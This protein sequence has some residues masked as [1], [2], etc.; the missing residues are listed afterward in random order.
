MILFESN[1]WI[2]GGTILYSRPKGFADIDGVKRSLQINDEIIK[3]IQN[4]NKPFV[5]IEDYS[6]LKGSSLKARKIFIDSMNDNELRENLIF[7]NT[8]L[9]STVAIKIGKK[10]NLTGKNI[11]I[12]NSYSDAIRRAQIEGKIPIK[13]QLEDDVLETIQNENANI[14]TLVPINILRKEEWQIRSKEFEN[15]CFVLNRNILHSK[16]IG[17]LKSKHIKQIDQMRDRC[18]ADLN[19]I[20]SSIDYIIVDSKGI[21][22]ATRTSRLAFMKSI[23]IW[24]S[25]HPLKLYCMYNTNTFMRTALNL[26]R[27]FLPFKIQVATDF[28]N[29]LEK[30]DQHKNETVDPIK[31]SQKN[32][33][34]KTISEN[35]LE[36]LV[37]LIGNINWEFKGLND[38][39]HHFDE[40]HPFYYISQSISLIKEELDDLVAERIRLEEQLFQSQKMESIGRLAG[41]IAHDFNNIL[42]IILGNTELGLDNLAEGHPAYNNLKDIKNGSLRG[43]SIVKQLLNFSRK[44]PLDFRIVKADKVLDKSL[45]FIRSAIPENIVINKKLQADEVAIKVDGTQFQQVIMNLFVNASQAIGHESGQIY[46]QS[47]T[48][49]LNENE[50]TQYVDLKAGSYFKIDIFDTGSGISADIKDKIFEPYFTTKDIG[51]GTGMGLAVVHG[52]IKNHK[53]AIQFESVPGEGCQFTILIPQVEFQTVVEKSPE[54]NREKSEIKKGRL[55]IVDDEKQIIEL[56]KDF[57]TAVGYSVCAFTS[58]EEAFDA[59]KADPNVYDLVVTDMVMPMMSG[60]V[61]SQKILEIRRDIPII[62]CTGHALMMGHKEAKEI[63]IAGFAEKP[64]LMK[65]L[66]EKIGKL[67]ET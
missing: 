27:P 54:N 65:E 63:G 19:T 29:A 36:K 9:V 11:I 60:A 46:V 40:T 15:R 4:E 35:D 43:A 31:K 61:L 67:L 24:H 45:D 2:I 55:L 8:S 6:F 41:G 20:G 26:A 62:L 49:N 56:E 64:I 37:G 1:F 47:S 57:L 52:I 12:T 22:S 28:Q 32:T 23:K 38:T 3:I 50:A 44:S 25:K 59:F 34:L 5:Q 18:Q 13:G 21:K 51:Q 33:K 48:I 42:H 30:I 39:D 7:C 10:F 53:G 14:Q 58:S 16:S 17:H 66:A